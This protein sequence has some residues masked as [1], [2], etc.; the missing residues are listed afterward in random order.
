M[1]VVE[2][3]LFTGSYAGEIRETYQQNN[4]KSTN[5]PL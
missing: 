5:L 1:P 3:W 4:K 2:V